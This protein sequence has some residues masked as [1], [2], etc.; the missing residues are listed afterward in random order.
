[1][2]L[3]NPILRTD[4][5]L[6]EVPED[7]SVK[8]L[9][10]ELNT[11]I[12]DLV[13]D[14]TAL[15]DP[16]FS[17]INT[18]LLDELDEETL[19][20]VYRYLIDALTKDNFRVC[21]RLVKKLLR[22]NN[23]IHAL[24][25]Y[26]LLIENESTSSLSKDDLFD[27]CI[28][29]VSRLSDDVD[30][31]YFELILPIIAKFKHIE[32]FIEVFSDQI[33][34]DSLI[35]KFILEPDWIR[36]LDLMLK[37]DVLTLWEGKPYSLDRLFALIKAQDNPAALLNS[38]LP[39]LVNSVEELLNLVVEITHLFRKQNNANVQ[40]Y[41]LQ[42]DGFFSY[43]CNFVKSAGIKFNSKEELVDIA[44]KLS[45]TASKYDNILSL[46]SILV[47]LYRL[48][49]ERLVSGDI[50]NLDKLIEIINTVLKTNFG[51]SVLDLISNPNIRSVFDS[52][53]S[54]KKVTNM[55][56]Y[57]LNNIDDFDLFSQK[58]SEL[59]Q[60]ITKISDLEDLI[61]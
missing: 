14:A 45:N 50:S 51:L 6:A 47:T 21:I 20:I 40:Y 46:E 34:L 39:K 54:F 57:V 56:Q 28:E 55:L 53:D 17:G 59:S 27:F 48:P 4:L 41:Y 35:K 33:I 58:V 1:M 19:K 37:K 13:E 26:F 11:R 9:R 49:L 15:L 8:S 52:L 31:S 44:K 23:P 36:I 42:K 25:F 29:F 24:K 32:A 5:P 16:M 10:L 38:E 2:T 12:F 30:P 43:V 61:G 18:L 3:E 7:H 60:P 22:R